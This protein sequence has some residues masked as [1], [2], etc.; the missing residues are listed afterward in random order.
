MGP[1]TMSAEERLDPLTQVPNALKASVA[2]H[3]LQIDELWLS[4]AKT[5]RL[6]QAY[7]E[8]LPPQ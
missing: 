6:W 1:R 7:L 8:R 5:D 2:I 4:Q 3:N